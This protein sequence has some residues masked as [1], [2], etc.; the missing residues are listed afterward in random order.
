MP[1]GL[2]KDC[3]PL[4][5]GGALSND[6]VSDRREQYQL[7]G[8]HLVTFQYCYWCAFTRCHLYAIYNI[9]R[10]EIAQSV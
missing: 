3:S 7:S 9:V 1:D 4:S 2:Q 5:G 10:A 6:H 8:L